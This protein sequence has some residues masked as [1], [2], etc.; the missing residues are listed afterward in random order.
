MK[1][2][3]AWVTYDAQN[4]LWL[5]REYWCLHAIAVVGVSLFGS[6]KTKAEAHHDPSG[7]VHAAQ[8]IGKYRGNNVEP[9]AKQFGWWLPGTPR[10]V[11]QSR[12]IIQLRF[13]VKKQAWRA[14]RR[15]RRP[16]HTAVFLPWR[17]PGSRRH[18][19]SS[20]WCCGPSRLGSALPLSPVPV[21]RHPGLDMGRAWWAPSSRYVNK[22]TWLTRRDHTGSH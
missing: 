11:F 21:T 10:G 15:R 20:N 13:D 14:T 19:P 8:P 7:H 1:R 22:P 18:T 12:F 3:E 16:D 5:P 4:V 6:V 9:R 17:A 2:N